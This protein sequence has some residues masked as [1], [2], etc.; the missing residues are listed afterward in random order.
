MEVTFSLQGVGWAERAIIAHALASF[1]AGLA[2]ALMVTTPSFVPVSTQEQTS[3]KKQKLVD[4]RHLL[5][6][7]Y[8][9]KSE[10]RWDLSLGTA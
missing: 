8:T 2:A 5:Y 3:V 1:Y 10:V 7:L 6:R 9:K 4:E